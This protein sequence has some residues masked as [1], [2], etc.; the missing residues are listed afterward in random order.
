MNGPQLGVE[1]R[2]YGMNRRKFLRHFGIASSAITFSPFFIERFF[3]VCQAANNLTRVYKV[4]NGDCFQNATK[5]WEMLDGPA[6]YIAPTDVVVIKA[7]AQ[8]PYQGYTHKGV[9]KGVI[10]QILQIPGFSG[11]VL[12]CDN[13]QTYGWGSGTVGFDAALEYR[14]HN[15]P[16]HN[17]NSLA[18]AYQ[19][20]GKPV[21]TKRWMNSPWRDISF[22]SVAVWNPSDGEGWTRNFFTF[23]SLD[24]FISYPVFQSPLNSSRMIDLKNGVWEN[25]QYTGR[26]V[27]TIVI[28]TLNNHGDASED[29][30]GVTS[31][32][33]SFFGATEI[34]GGAGG[35][36]NGYY[37]MHSSG[38]NGGAQTVGELVGRYIN[39]FYSPSLYITA[40]MWSGWYSRTGDAVETKTVLACTNPVTLDYVACRDVISPYAPWLNPD[41]NTHTRKQILGCMS[42]G[43]GAIDPARFEVISFDFNKPSANRLDVERKI[44]DLKAGA[45]TEQQVKDTINLYMES[46]QN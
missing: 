26:R 10:D 28:P 37:Q 17:W 45:A 21:A 18:A 3:S 13:T 31:A 33:K 7:N 27:K 25:G 35:R 30:A 39:S 29:E 20:K 14:A 22:P 4:I 2:R 32:V 42:Q 16:D 24:T 43:I 44:R 15:W 12:I 11:E 38:F 40:A 36:L 8:W 9:I 34:P 5:L 23:H 46:N 6:K 41:Q 19:A 1:W